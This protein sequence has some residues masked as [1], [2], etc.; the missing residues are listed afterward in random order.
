VGRDVVLVSFRGRGRYYLGPALSSLLA[1]AILKTTA[2]AAQTSEAPQQVKPTQPALPQIRVMGRR[3]VQRGPVRKPQ[4]QAAAPSLPDN[5]QTPWWPTL[6]AYTTADAYAFVDIPGRDVAVGAVEN[7]RVSLR[8]RNLT[9]AVY[10]AWSDTT[11]PD[12]ILL[13][14]PRTY[15]IAASARW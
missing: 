15:E 9:N 2:A 4:P 12:Q 6:N 8:V 7:L 1:V 5:K 11:Y 3:A 13:G 14:A 10:A